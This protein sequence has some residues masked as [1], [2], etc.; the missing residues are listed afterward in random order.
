MPGRQRA[1][2]TFAGDVNHNGSSDSKN[3]TIEKA[4]SVTAVTCPAS[5]T[6]NGAAQTPCTATVSGV[7]GLNDSLT[8]NYTDNVNAGTASASATFAG[9]TNYNG[10]NDSKNFTIEKAATVTTVTCGTGPFT[11]NGNPHTPC[12]ASVTGPGLNESL[13]V[14][15]TDNMNAGTAT[16]SASYAESVNYLGSTDS[17]NFTIEKA[18]SV[19]SVTCPASVTYNG[20]AQTPCTAT[21]TGVG[22]LNQALTV[23]YTNNINAGTATASA[24]FAG[25]ANH[26]GSNDSKNFTSKRLPQ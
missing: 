1:S 10:S 26:N 2:A 18:G 23:N 17:K 12:T 5:V 15:Y 25:D 3:F 22:G 14:N 24:T 11:Y 4:A 8:V 13:T 16:A 7:G 21:V 9:D 6:Y 19:T 20:A